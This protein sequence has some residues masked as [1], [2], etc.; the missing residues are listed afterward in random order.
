MKKLQIGIMGSAADLKFSDDALKFAKN[1]GKL[2]ADSRNILVYGAESEYTSLSTEAA[3]EASK[4][5]G[6]TVGVAGGK[7]KNI[8]GEFSPTVLINSG[9]E[10]GGGREFTLV[11]SCDVIIAISGGSGT[12]T[13]MAIAYQAGI[14]IIVVDKFG[15]WANELSNRFIDDRKRLKCISVKTEEDALQKALEEGM[16]KYENTKC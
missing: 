3:I 8:F 1:L 13:E 14:P 5:N 6:I 15:G 10:I 7:D 9:L 4:N 12:L 2:I 16:K 11:L